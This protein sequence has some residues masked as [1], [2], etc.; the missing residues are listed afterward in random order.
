MKYTRR[1]IEKTLREH[2]DFFSVV[3]ITGPRQSGKSTLLLHVLKDY[4]YVTFDDHMIVESFYDDP[5]RFMRNNDNKIIFDEVQKV[6][7]L[8]SAVHSLIEEKTGKQFILTGSSARK[9]K[10]TGIDLL[11]GRVLLKTLHPFILSELTS[12]FS[13]DQAL[14]YGLLPV[15]LSSKNPQDVLDTYA[16]LYVRE[17]VQQEGLVRTIGD[18]SRFLEAISFSHGSLLNVSYV[19]RECEV[20]RKVVESYIKILE[21]IL[22]SFR[23]PIFTKKRLANRQI[24]C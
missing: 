9:L 20:E 14:K 24:I 21:D 17:E 19:A 12:D 11:A 15:V 10:R 7:E 22:L 2:L 1:E 13:F 4:K 16:A 8:L 3:G 6:P 5:K 18:F 23:L